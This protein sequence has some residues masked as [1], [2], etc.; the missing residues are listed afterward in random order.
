MCQPPPESYFGVILGGAVTGAIRPSMGKYHDCILDGRR[1]IF[2]EGLGCGIRTPKG[3]RDSPRCP[4]D[5]DPW[6]FYSLTVLGQE[7][8]ILGAPKSDTTLNTARSMLPMLI[9]LSIQII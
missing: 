7:G 4:I 1:T 8:F 3:G 9:L 5:V 2:R 6:V